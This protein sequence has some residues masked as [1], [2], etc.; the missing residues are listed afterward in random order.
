MK[1]TDVE[2]NK[3]LFDFTL[4]ESHPMV[5]LSLAQMTEAELLGILVR[6]MTT[7]GLHYGNLE[8]MNKGGSWCIATKAESVTA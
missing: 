2:I 3:Q 1:F 5:A 4:D 7:A 8:E 6:A